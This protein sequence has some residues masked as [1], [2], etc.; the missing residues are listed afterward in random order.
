MPLP[1]RERAGV[2][3]P[4]SPLDKSVCGFQRQRK[5]RGSK[6]D[7]GIQGLLGSLAYVVCLH[8]YLRLEI[9]DPEAEL[10]TVCLRRA[11]RLM[12]DTDIN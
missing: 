5:Y 11:P 9:G 8:A 6:R 3:V 2:E 7:R 4:S 12:E 10:T 1:R